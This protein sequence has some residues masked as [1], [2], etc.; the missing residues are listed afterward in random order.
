MH[1]AISG[2]SYLNRSPFA[3]GNAPFESPAEAIPVAESPSR[4]AVRFDGDAMNFPAIA[5]NI[6]LYLLFYSVSES[7]RDGSPLKC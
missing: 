7:G 4:E 1:I 2:L 3:D 6:N 5:F